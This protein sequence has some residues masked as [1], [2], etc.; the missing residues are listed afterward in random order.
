MTRPLPRGTTSGRLGGLRAHARF[1]R[2]RQQSGGP[3]AR[4]ARRS[5]EAAVRS[6][7]PL[8]IARTGEAGALL[9]ALS[10]SLRRASQMLARS[11]E[12]VFA[13]R[14]VAGS[15]RRLRGSGGERRR[16]G[17]GAHREVRVA[18]GRCLAGRACR[19]PPRSGTRT[20]GTRRPAPRRLR[21]QRA[22]HPNCDVGPR[23]LLEPP[24]GVSIELALDPRPRA[25][26]RLKFPGIL[27]PS[28]ESGATDR[29]PRPARPPRR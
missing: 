20:D 13:W 21:G 11:L 24:D 5:S 6:A 27:G 26:Y 2:R 23:G 17:T 9:S 29:R 14:R 28:A 10:G 3:T 19:L 4:D 1:R 7:G 8:A 22:R 16:F 25:G 12:Q 15:V 18:R